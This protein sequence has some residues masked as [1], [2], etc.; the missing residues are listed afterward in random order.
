MNL[1]NIVWMDENG[2][3]ITELNSRVSVSQIRRINGSTYARDATVTP[4]RNE[5]NGTYVCEAVVMGDF[6]TSEAASESLD[7]IVFGELLAS[8]VQ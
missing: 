2:V 4:L 7:V 5:D 8:L 6:V 1:V 3:P